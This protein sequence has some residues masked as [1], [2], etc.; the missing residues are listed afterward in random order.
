MNYLRQHA[1]LIILV[2]VLSTSCP[3]ILAQRIEL[4]EEIRDIS[5][6]AAEYGEAGQW[7]Q[8]VDIM[9]RK[10]DSLPDEEEMHPYRAFIHFNLGY[11]YSEKPDG[12]ISANL[13]DAVE[14]YRRAIEYERDDVHS[15]T[16]LVLLLQQM[17]D[18]GQAIDVLEQGIINDQ[19]NSG[20]YYSALGDTYQQLG[21][22]QEAWDA[23]QE[24]LSAEY[25]DPTG[26]IKIIDLFDSFP[27]GELP[28]LYE[29][30]IAFKEE[31]SYEVASIGLLSILRRT[32]E[33][34][35]DLFD[36]ALLS[37]T[38][39][40]IKEGWVNQ[41]LITDLEIQ[42]E[43]S[44]INVLSSC[45]IEWNGDADPIGCL[46]DTNWWNNNDQRRFYFLAFQKAYADYLL[47]TSQVDRAFEIY[48]SAMTY[49]NN[50]E[51]NDFSFE[52]YG[53]SHALIIEIYTTLAQ[54]YNSRVD[55]SRFESIEQITEI[56]EQRF[57]DMKSG[58]YNRG[59][60]ESIQKFHTA[61]AL[62]Y[63]DR[64]KWQGFGATNALFQLRGAIG[65]AQRRYRENPDSYYPLPLLQNYFAYGL[66]IAK[67]EPQAYE[68][69][70]EAALA[71]LETDN[72][73][74]AQEMLNEA[75]AFESQVKDEWIVKNEVA[76]SILNSRQIIQ[77]LNREAF[78]TASASYYRT[79]EVFKWMD[80]MQM[81]SAIDRAIVDRQR[82]K[83]LVDLGQRAK[84]IGAKEAY[85][86]LAKRARREV[87][88]DGVYMEQDI[89][90][91]KKI[92]LAKHFYRHKPLAQYLSESLLIKSD[93]E[94]VKIATPPGEQIRVIPID[95]K[96]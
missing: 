21:V 74:L 68:M 69:Y 93:I 96:G 18:W 39:I 79:T 60:L 61:L 8:A 33:S 43:S 14:H 85:D 19:H 38:G 47:S 78:D 2:S 11:I 46:D 71:Y 49:L 34:H 82:F 24:A 63:V 88:P 36:Q 72:L 41:N 52:I 3:S 12:V 22:Y 83:A 76:K 10:L 31:G 9:M 23:Y 73:G 87:K 40:I 5:A 90:R 15:I 42:C 29:Q 35:S 75:V 57:F 58:A 92:G 1:R 86:E 6:K 44:A 89:S 17:E 66:V 65:I 91:I 70:T 84:D 48:A 32:C 13:N 37:W 4:K 81:T 50:S 56:V 20:I 28:L 53:Y 77:T 30:C 25:P 26:K 62:I 95:R 16:N 94:F 54:L 51:L 67:R 55:S 45:L 27:S 59:D 7:D 64:G 80:D